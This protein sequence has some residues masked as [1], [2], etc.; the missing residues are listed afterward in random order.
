MQ[1]LKPLHLAG[2]IGSSISQDWQHFARGRR[3]LYTSHQ[4]IKA[5][6]AP[7]RSAIVRPMVQRAEDDLAIVSCFFNPGASQRR[8]DN[9]RAFLRGM[10]QSGVR[11]LLVELAFGDNP[12]AIEHD[13]VIQLRSDDLL[14]HKERL[15][16]IGIQ[17]LL[18]DGARKIAWLDG[19]IRFDNPC[20]PRVISERLEQVNLCQVFEDVSVQLHARGAPVVAPSA[21][22]YHQRTGRFYTQQPR[23]VKGLLLGQHMAGQ[24]GYGWAA[25]AEVLEQALLFDK[26]VVGG[27]D[28]LMLTATM[29]RDLD[30]PRLA[31]T[32]YSKFH[33]QD[34]DHRNRSATYTSHYLEWAARWNRAVAGQV[35]FAPLHLRDMYHGRRS[36]RGYFT[37]LD[38]LYRHGYDPLVDLEED[39]AGCLQWSSPK[40]A[41]HREVEAYFLSRREDV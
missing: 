14:W 40:E 15:L 8:I 38:I 28:K 41:M 7:L 1:A 24:C 23:V 12:H 17:R 26:A 16:N 18:Q 31:A 39:A 13:D 32:T 21:I 19:D 35:G 36:D 25:R 34:C 6:K 11:C 3:A 10:R 30:N 29:E 37:R 33:C 5:V 2:R 27:G 4:A 9:Y 22:S 20:W